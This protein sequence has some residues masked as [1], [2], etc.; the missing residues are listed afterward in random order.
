MG[1]GL[2]QIVY[3]SKKIGLNAIGVE[4]Q[5]RLKAAHNELGINV[6]Y[7]DFFNMDLSFL[8][9]QDIVYLYRPIDNITGLNN[10]LK[11]IY[12]NTGSNVIVIFSMLPVPVNVGKFKKAEYRS[13][14]VA[15]GFIDCLLYKVSN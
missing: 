1:C 9:Q 3:F 6:I 5:T 13:P 14:A 11:L 7:G 8:K 12:E 2:G 15:T 10:L 4:Y